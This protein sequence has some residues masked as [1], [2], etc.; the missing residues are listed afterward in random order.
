AVLAAGLAVAFVPPATGSPIP[1]SAP[2]LL[3]AM[4]RDLG[5]TADQVTTRI[6]QEQRASTALATLTG[7]LGD[8]FA[9]SWFD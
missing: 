9:G 3:T 5:L 1:D 2:G 6:A 4:Q 8:S 7:K